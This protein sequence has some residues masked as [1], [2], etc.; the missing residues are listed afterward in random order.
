MEA[1][2]LEGADQDRRKDFCQSEYAKRQT[3]CD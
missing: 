1:G 3:A 2:Q